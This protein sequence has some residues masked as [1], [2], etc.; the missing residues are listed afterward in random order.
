ML[1]SVII[2]TYNRADLLA[3]CLRSLQA[4]GVP[5]LEIIVVDDGGTDNSDEIVS[6]FSGVRYLR[7]A[8][9]GP[10]TARNFGFSASRGGYVAFIDSDDEW[11]DGHIL[12]LAAQLDANPD[13]SVV[14]ADS[15]MGNPES[16]FVSFIETFGRDQFHALPHQNRDGLRVLERRPFL[17][18]L[19][20]RNV[21]FLGSMLFRRQ[22]F[23]AL[24]GFDGGL[25]GAADWDVF[26]RA[27][28]MDTV[29]FSDGPS[30]SR[31]YRHSAAMSNDI[32]HMQEDSIRALESVCR[33]SELDSDE[34]AHIEGRLRELSFGW[35]YHAYDRGD[36]KAAR[37]RLQRQTGSRGI[38]VREGAY[39]LAT[40]LPPGLVI[41][42]RKARR[43]LGI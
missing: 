36:F 34:R 8:N 7:Q 9:A 33:R 22:A 28:A 41:A 11:I 4:A 3:R 37:D 17:I 1:V 23:E 15:A 25:C 19:S 42:M 2:P 43:V 35:A 27:V 29:A 38:G 6:S 5:D 16:G 32:D 14:F 26:M 30:V 13:V 10:A 20:T 40:Y 21:M 39:L 31:Y 12:R 24:G 18:H